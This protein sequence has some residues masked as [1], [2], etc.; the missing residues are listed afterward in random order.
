MNMK[1]NKP[2]DIHTLGWAAERRLRPIGFV[3]VGLCDC[4]QVLDARGASPREAWEALYRKFID[5]RHALGL[6]MPWEETTQVAAV[7][8]G[9]MAC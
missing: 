5:H 3:E 6:A 7:M 2:K 9:G 4:G 1:S 8:G